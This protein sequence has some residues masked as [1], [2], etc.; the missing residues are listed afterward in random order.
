LRARTSLIDEGLSGLNLAKST[1]FE[2]TAVRVFILAPFFVIALSAF[3]LSAD[4]NCPLPQAVAG[5]PFTS[6]SRTTPWPMDYFT[7]NRILS[8]QDLGPMTALKGI[9]LQQKSNAWT[10]GEA[11]R[12]YLEDVKPADSRTLAIR[13]N[14]RTF[15]STIGQSELKLVY[16]GQAHAIDLYLST[17]DLQVE[18]WNKP[19]TLNTLV[20]SPELRTINEIL[21]VKTP[22]LM[23]NDNSLEYFAL[24]YSYAL[25]SIKQLGSVS[26]VVPAARTQLTGFPR[27]VVINELH[28]LV[29]TNWVR[30]MPG[31]DCLKAAG[32]KKITVGLEGYAKGRS[33]T[34][35]EVLRRRSMIEQFQFRADRLG[36]SMHDLLERVFPPDLVAK[37]LSGQ[38]QDNPGMTAFIRK[39]MEYSAAGIMIDLSGLEASDYDELGK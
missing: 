28:G 36:I 18:Y 27:A 23:I 11:L 15:L 19:Y 16:V 39:L 6:I 21:K 7:L 4:I 1:G 25:E 13:E 38:V 10:G 22:A 30:Q 29:S 12:A 32:I 34:L 14:L 5:D 24:P 37:I 20:Q 26:A 2:V 8:G 17:P 31:A 33:F 35:E 3:G 9:T